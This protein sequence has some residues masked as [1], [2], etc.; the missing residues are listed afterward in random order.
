[1]KELLQGCDETKMSL[2][3][4]D[5]LNGEIPDDLTRVEFRLRREALKYLEINPSSAVTSISFL[6]FRGGRF[7]ILTTLDTK[8]I[9]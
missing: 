9:F 3:F 7:K 8:I 2:I 5:C 6:F 4:N 1:M